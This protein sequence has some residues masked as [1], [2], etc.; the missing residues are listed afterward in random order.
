LR[1]FSFAWY[2]LNRRFI[3][4]GVI[5]E[6]ISNVDGMSRYQRVS[7]RGASNSYS[8]TISKSNSTLNVGVA[9]SEPYDNH[10]FREL[11]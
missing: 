9:D 3:D 2:T 7:I 10:K 8:P 6:S 5:D 4:G 1:G 11:G